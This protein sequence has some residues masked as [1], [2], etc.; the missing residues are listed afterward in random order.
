MRRVASLLIAVFIVV[1]GG[2]VAVA[3]EITL[4]PDTYDF[5]ATSE[6]SV[7]EQ[8]GDVNNADNLADTGQS[9]L[10]PL[11]VAG[12][13]LAVAAVVAVSRRKHLVKR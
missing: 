13:A 12:G 9:P 8:I 11:L 1:S 2:G 10:A 7:S 5:G 3:Q 6:Y 4:E